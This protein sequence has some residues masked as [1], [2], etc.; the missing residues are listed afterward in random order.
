ME[1]RAQGARADHLAS[2]NAIAEPGH[3]L[4][5][6]LQTS[7]GYVVGQLQRRFTGLAS[8]FLCSVKYKIGHRILKARL[9][10]SLRVHVTCLLTNYSN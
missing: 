4:A 8:L 3:L 7:G 10:F 6:Y 5:I 2:V 9:S 1:R